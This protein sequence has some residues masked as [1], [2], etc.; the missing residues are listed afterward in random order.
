MSDAKATTKSIPANSQLQKSPNNG[1]N[2]M[3]KNKTQAPKQLE[4]ADEMIEDS[5]SWEAA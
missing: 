5:Y 4:D 3:K 1:N 2:K